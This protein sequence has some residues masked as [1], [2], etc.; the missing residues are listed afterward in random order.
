MIYFQPQTFAFNHFKYYAV[1]QYWSDKMRPAVNTL[2]NT[3]THSRTGFGETTQKPIIFEYRNS[4]V[5]MNLLAL[6]CFGIFILN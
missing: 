6:R 5:F 2:R 3:E 1:L 4:E